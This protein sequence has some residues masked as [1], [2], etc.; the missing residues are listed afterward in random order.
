MTLAMPVHLETD[1]L[2]LRPFEDAD[3]AGLVAI[4]SDWEVT[5]WLSRNVPFPFREADGAGMIRQRRDDQAAGR[6][7][8]Y[9]VFDKVTGAQ[10]GGVRLFALTGTAEIGY[11]FG[12]A[13][14]GR[15]YATEMLQAV[16]RAC[17]EHSAIEELVAQTAADNIGS[18][19]ILEKAGFVYQ[20]QTP[21]EYARCGHT[22][23]CGEFF[24]LS[25][26]HW[27]KQQEKT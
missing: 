25:K 27:F 22:H 15:G 20:G 9:G 19:R 21:E 5:R 13:A 6:G 4:L 16:V 1:R 10:L 26:A 12:R 14:W 7:M 17:F 11:W 3:V 18:R 23:G 2:I 8:A 24:R